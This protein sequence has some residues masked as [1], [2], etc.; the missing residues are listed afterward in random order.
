MKKNNLLSFSIYLL[1]HTGISQHGG[2]IIRKSRTPV[3]QV[4]NSG[5]GEF[6]FE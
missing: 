1:H 2:A 3:L 6:S 4:V 5:K